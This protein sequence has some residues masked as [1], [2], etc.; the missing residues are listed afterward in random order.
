MLLVHEYLVF[1]FRRR[2]ILLLHLI[3]MFYCFYLGAVSML[4]S[5]HAS[6]CTS[7]CKHVKCAAQSVKITYTTTYIFYFVIERD[8]QK[9]LIT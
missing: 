8:F 6:Y 5:L 2:A 7:N 3:I 1:P 9:K 4:S